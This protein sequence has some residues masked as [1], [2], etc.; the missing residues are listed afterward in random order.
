MKLTSFL[1]T[2]LQIYLPILPK[3]VHKVIVIY[4]HLNIN[5]DISLKKKNQADNFKNLSN[6][7]FNK[8]SLESLENKNSTIDYN[9]LE[10]ID[11]EIYKRMCG[12][13]Y[14]LITSSYAS[15]GI[16]KAL[17]STISSILTKI[18]D[19][20]TFILIMLNKYI[21]FNYFI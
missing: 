11:E 10:R 5:L 7:K 16:Q 19:E 6:A 4:L 2:Y 17:K 20:V 21:C 15:K 18:F 13:F 12:K 9:N 1:I 8:K 14:D 3:L